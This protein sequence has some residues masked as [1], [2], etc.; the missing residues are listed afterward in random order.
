MPDR[1]SYL[2]EGLPSPIPWLRA[3]VR[4]GNSLKKWVEGMRSGTLLN[5]ALSLGDLF[6][7]ETF[8]NSLR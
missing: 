2:W 3:L 7:P 5:D 8:L 6:H 1:W 4:R